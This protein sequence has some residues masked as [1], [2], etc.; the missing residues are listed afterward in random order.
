MFLLSLLAV[1]AHA[2][3]ITDPSMQL[4]DPECG[5]EFGV[6]CQSLVGT[7]FQFTTLTGD[8]IF[9]F[10]NKNPENSVV[11][12]SILIQETGF[13]AAQIGCDTG[14]DFTD[15]NTGGAYIFSSCTKFDT[16]S[17]FTGLYF[18]NPRLVVGS[19]FSIE[20]S[21]GIYTGGNFFF[22]LNACPNC[23][24]AINE[25]WNAPQTFYGTVNLSLEEAQQLPSPTSVPEPAS[26][27]L[28]GSGCAAVLSRRLRKR[29]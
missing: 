18:S 20:A 17:G 7:T 29:G 13:L 8:G 19:P 23:S 24:P 22:D 12:T 15:P 3:G 6:P 4:S 14:P 5:G 10:T 2:D 11:I 25:I 9:G 28:L 1:C 26:L 16:E 27:I 21:P